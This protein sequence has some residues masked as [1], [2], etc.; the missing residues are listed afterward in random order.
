MRVLSAAV[1]VV[2]LSVLLPTCAYSQPETGP[3]DDAGFAFSRAPDEVV[4]QLS[5]DGGLI[6]NPDPM[7]FVRVFGDGRVI[8]HYPVY[9][10][11]AGDYVL[12]LSDQELES[13]LATFAKEDIVTVNEPRMEEML[14]EARIETGPVEPPEDH[15]ATVA[16]EMRFESV[17]ATAPAAPPLTDVERRIAVP[18]S[19]VETGIRAPSTTLQGIA[20]GIR[21]LEDL[22]RR[23]DLEKISDGGR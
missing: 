11:K 19:A 18:V 22:A 13:L 21:Q 16:V 23:P 8:V 3:S 17:P 6:E 15:G 14:A 20:A 2:G 12:R 5:Y 7:P 4:L 9:M 10:K 1:L